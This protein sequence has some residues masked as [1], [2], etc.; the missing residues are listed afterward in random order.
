[1][2]TCACG[3]GAPIKAGSNWKYKRGH[4]SNPPGGVTVLDRS[5]D[6]DFDALATGVELEDLENS[7]LAEMS[8]TIPDDPAPADADADDEEPQY[9]KDVP[10]KVTKRVRDDV[11]GKVAMFL[12]ML[13]GGLSMVDPICGTAVLENTPPI[14][15]KLTPILCKSPAIVKY[16]RSTTG[17]L[18]WAELG[19]ACF[20]LGKAIAQHHL[21]GPQPGPVPGVD[22]DAQAPQQADFAAYGV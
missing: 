22:F 7:Y 17:F 21:F 18:L 2:A 19:M 3:C 1:M 5:V 9:S 4:K 15:E 14:A 11:E 12:T 13:G 10:V 20:P 8:D 6:V 16:F